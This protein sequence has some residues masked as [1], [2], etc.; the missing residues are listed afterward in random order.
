MMQRSACKRPLVLN[1]DSLT[2]DQPVPQWHNLPIMGVPAP[3]Q[4]GTCKSRILKNLHQE[5]TTKATIICFAFLLI[6]SRFCHVSDQYHLFHNMFSIPN[7]NG[8][9]DV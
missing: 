5:E 7:M 6:L 2:V 1:S 3:D 9:S 8:S 4:K